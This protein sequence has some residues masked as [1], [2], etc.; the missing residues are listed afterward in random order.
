MS[1]VE[2]GSGQGGTDPGSPEEERHTG[3]PVPA[4]P[5]Q[6]GQADQGVHTVRPGGQLGGEQ[7]PGGGVRPWDCTSFDNNKKLSYKHLL[8]YYKSDKVLIICFVVVFW[9]FFGFGWRK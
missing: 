5:E 2:E 7:A 4:L 8:I 1:Q 6:P 9:I 3:L